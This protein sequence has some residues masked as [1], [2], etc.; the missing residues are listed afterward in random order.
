[1]TYTIMSFLVIGDLAL[2][3]WFVKLCIN[4]W[5]RVDGKAKFTVGDYTV[6]AFCVSTWIALGV[7]II[8]KWFK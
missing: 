5:P 2:T 6:A 3:A 7:L 4:Y 1:M 8:M